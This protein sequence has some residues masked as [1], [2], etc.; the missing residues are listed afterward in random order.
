[1]RILI[2]TEI[3]APFRI[4]LFNA[5]AREH[6]VELQVC[7]LAERDPRR[8]HYRVYRD[9]FAFDEVVLPGIGLRRGGRWLM[10]NRGVL[11]LL[12]RTRPDVI[13]A[14]GWNQP[15]FW[16]VLLAARLTRTPALLWVE[17]TSRDARVGGAPARRLRR[18]ALCLAVGF[19][20][21]GRASREYLRGLG[22]PDE[23]IAVAPNAV[24]LRIF[25]ERVDAERTDRAALCERLGLDGCV[26]LYVG[27]LDAE[28]GLD[29]LLGAMRD[30]PGTLV[31]IG[32]GPLEPELRRSAGERVR[33]LGALARDELV[34]WY[35]AADVLVLP[36][37]SEPWG[38]VLNEAAAAGLP[39]VA[40]EAVG[41][42]HDLIEPGGNGFRVPVDDQAALAEA[43]RSLAADPELRA[44]FGRRSREL[45]ERF[46]P[47]DWAA[48][49]AAFASAT[50]EARSAARRSGG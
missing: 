18:L 21:P 8:T 48:A 27:R 23:R 5:L 14:G 6:G 31:L 47:E 40:T 50:V 34:P 45:S 16:Q 3:P 25:V 29:I 13:V 33:L 24:E 4:P 35:A 41:A 9:E 39:L 7:F 12:R 44:A 1:M 37:R 49:I 15:T 46:R 22:V 10:L 36:S 32:S 11:R 43:L 19:V 42:A 28:K 2:V 26:F 38:M 20:V 17:S 30:V